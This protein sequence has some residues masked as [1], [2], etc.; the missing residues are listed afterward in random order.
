[1][2]AVV[3]DCR[4]SSLFPGG[5]IHSRSQLLDAVEGLVEQFDEAHPM[6]IGPIGKHALLELV[7]GLQV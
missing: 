5:G 4:T 2:S 3:N 1:M 7:D 6:R